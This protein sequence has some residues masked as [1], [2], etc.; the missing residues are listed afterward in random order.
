MR[1][2]TT[3]DRPCSRART[4]CRA[5][6]SGFSLP[7]RP[8]RVLPMPARAKKPVCTGPGSKVVTVTPVRRSS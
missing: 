8:S 6:S 4:A 1:P 5:T 2:P 7:I 3:E